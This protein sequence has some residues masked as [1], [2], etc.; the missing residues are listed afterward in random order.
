MNKPNNYNETLA[1]LFDSRN[2]GGF[3]LK[4]N[5]ST[6][7]ELQSVVANLQPGGK[8]YVKRVKEETRQNSADT[9]GIDY[10]RTIA[11]YLEYASPEKVEAWK[12]KA[13]S[14]RF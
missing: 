14:D 2:G 13:S 5:E 8:L 10:E 9:K 11:A 4:L 12:A 3:E 6:I 1:R 7:A